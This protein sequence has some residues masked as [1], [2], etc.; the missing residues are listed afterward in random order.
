MQAM[1]LG[2]PVSPDKLPS[3]LDNIMESL[4]SYAKT[5]LIANVVP[6]AV[7]LAFTVL[8]LV[9]WLV[10]RAARLCCCRARRQRLQHGPKAA[11]LLTGRKAWILKALVVLAA[12]GGVAGV[13]QLLQA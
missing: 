10:W 4:I 7:A 3:S 13:K 9:V 2:R 5:A 12:L 8:L 11:K 6:L 1:P